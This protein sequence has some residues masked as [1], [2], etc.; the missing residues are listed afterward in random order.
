MKGF[1]AMKI[2]YNVQGKERK[3]L[4]NTIAETVNETAVY[5]KA[6]TYAY[7]IGTYRIDRNG[8]L[9]FDV[10]EVS[11]DEINAVVEALE[12]AGFEGE[13]GEDLPDN[14]ETE[15]E[16]DD[17]PQTEEERENGADL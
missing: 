12:E 5:E 1:I 14:A 4:V 17:S 2:N 8:T 7:T 6:P 9:E 13:Q 3:T 10:S 16:G 15:D 11:Q